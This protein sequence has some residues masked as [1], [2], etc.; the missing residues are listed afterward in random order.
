MN[1]MHIAPTTLRGNKTAVGEAVSYD[2]VAKEYGEVVALH[3]TTMTIERGEFFSII[4]PSGSGKT[5]L[6]GVT[7]GFIPPSR[8]G[9]LV[10]GRDLVGVPPFQRNIGMVFQSYSLFPYMTV[11]QNIGFPLRMRK[12]S[13]GDQ[14]EKI[15]RM[16]E[17]VRLVDMGDRYPRQLSGGQQQRVALARAAIYDPVLLLM[18]EPLSALDKNLREDM[19]REL[20]AFQAMLGMTVIYVTHDQHEAA[21]MSHRIAI[22][23][24]GSVTQV[25]APRELYDR[26]ANRFVAGFLGEANIFEVESYKSVD[27]THTIIE[28]REGF[29]IVSAE[30]PP[31]ATFAVCVRPERMRVHID[32][33][34]TINQ[35]AGVITDVV[36]SAGMIHY[37][38][39]IASGKELNQK[40]S[41]NS[42]APSFDVGQNVTLSWTAQDSQLVAE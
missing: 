23:N 21:S 9:V 31:A 2:G 22:M 14:D 17:M 4:G 34:N 10:G 7:A 11:A 18:D 38:I 42:A 5:T 12:L 20:K 27:A 30:R 15:K 3:A 35:L 19:Q 37:R 33:S 6:L 39:R 32:Q 25:G 29:R 8:G 40:I 41:M 36:H 26:P 13:R 28:S 24:R 16:L 1:H